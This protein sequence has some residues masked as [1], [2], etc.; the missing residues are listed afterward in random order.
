ME[1]ET[2][3]KLIVV[4][5]AVLL[6]LFFFIAA[7]SINKDP[8]SG[9]AIN[10]E[11]INDPVNGIV[12]LSSLPNGDYTPKEIKVKLGTKVRIEGNPK[13]LVG[14]MDTL[15]IDGYGLSKKISENDYVL[16]FTANST[17]EF[18]VHCA[19]GMGNGKLIVGN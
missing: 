8:V 18:K 15:I 19:N 4:G 13:T 5:V 12:K 14:G 7:K 2:K 9:N 1:K 16:E 17:G 3:L 6:F 11:T 10:V